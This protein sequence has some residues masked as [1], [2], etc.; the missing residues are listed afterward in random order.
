M[1]SI[2]HKDTQK[3]IKGWRLEEGRIYFRRDTEQAFYF[4]LTLII[5]FA[6]LL[7]K[8]GIL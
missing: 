5:I 6:G 2:T 1:H 7:Y 4:I 3:V 8:I